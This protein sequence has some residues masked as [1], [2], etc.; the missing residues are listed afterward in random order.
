MMICWRR[1]IMEREVLREYAKLIAVGGINVMPGQE[2]VIRTAPE[3]LDFLEMLVEECYLA[4]ASRVTCEWRY[5]PITCLNIKYQ[6]EE[7]LGE[8]P[9]WEEE[10]WRERVK[11]LPANIYLESDDP[12]GFALVDQEKWAKAQQRRFAVIRKYRDAMENCYQWCV[13]AVP[14]RKWAMKVFPGVPEDEAVELLWKAILKCSRAEE[15][16]LEAWRRHSENLHRRCETLNGLRLRR[17]V[18]KS[19]K[20][21]TDFSVGLMP[22][23]RFLGGADRLETPEGL[24]RGVEYNAN[25]PSE[26]VFTTPMKG[27]AEGIV[28]S[29]RPLSYRGVMIEDFSIR[30]EKGRAVEVRAAKNEETLRLMVSMDDGASMLGECA[31]VPYSSPIRESGIVFCSTLFDE[32]ASC[33]LALGDGY[34]MCLENA[35]SYT[36]EQARAIG[37]NE[38][39]IHEDFMIGSDDL[40]VV[41]ITESGAE[42][43]IFRNGEWA[44]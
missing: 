5:D 31:F 20:T 11:T 32:N 40:S 33:H 16:P 36:P 25:I 29:T 44:I 13:A 26:E 3:Q 37:V 34:S 39:I 38:S 4:G 12:D 2:V 18:Y 35:S 9:S 22:Q 8:V 17:L 30:F 27:D 19:E 14:G 10:R 21:G 23:M 28:Y 7:K 41:G 15:N 1:L 43:Q 42:V 24:A 6:S